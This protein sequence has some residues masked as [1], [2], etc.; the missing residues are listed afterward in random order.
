MARN[1]KDK[2]SIVM[3]CY[4][5]LV[6]RSDGIIALA[7]DEHTYLEKTRRM[8]A[9]YTLPRCMPAAFPWKPRPFEL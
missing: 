9:A 4:T 1:V 2:M 8:I 5:C 7:R 6:S 3:L